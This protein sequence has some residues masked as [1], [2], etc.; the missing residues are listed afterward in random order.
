MK[1]NISPLKRYQIREVVFIISAFIC[2]SMYLFLTASEFE[3]FPFIRALIGGSV[4]GIISAFF[5]MK[6]SKKFLRKFNF[7]SNILIAILYYYVTFIA[8]VYSLI[9]STEVYKNGLDFNTALYHS[10]DILFSS[11]IQFMFLDLFFLIFIVSLIRQTRIMAGQNVISNYVKG[12]YHNPRSEERFF[13]FLDLKSSTEI[14]EKLGHQKYSRFLKKFFLEIDEI[15]LETSGIIYQYVG[16]EVVMIWHK[17]DGIENN[18]VIRFFSLLDSRFNL[19]RDDFI[20][21][22]GIFPEFKA[23]LHF[24]EV[25]ITEVGGILKTDIAYHGDPINTTSRIC[26]KCKELNKH[27]LVSKEVLDLLGNGDDSFKIYNEG[28]HLLKGKKKC[29]ELFSIEQRP[30]LLE[31]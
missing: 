16:D 14:A 5:E 8:L 31:T 24:G 23:G 21:E 20:S 2:Y 10:F 11:Q 28:R 18:N 9:V 15:T 4:L 25:S 22:F 17:K 1:L 19:L 26:V 7:T 6:L 13:M 12:R 30:Q 27:L 3:D 29:V